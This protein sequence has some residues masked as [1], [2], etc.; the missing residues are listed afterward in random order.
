MRR[1]S[2]MNSISYIIYAENRTRGIP[3]TLA[4]QRQDLVWSARVEA[5]RDLDIAAE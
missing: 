4:T 5:E 2:E 1:N 3:E